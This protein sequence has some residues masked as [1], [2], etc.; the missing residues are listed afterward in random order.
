M[1]KRIAERFD[2][3]GVMT[4]PPDDDTDDDSGDTDPECGPEVDEG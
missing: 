3:H 4:L 1:L 2:A